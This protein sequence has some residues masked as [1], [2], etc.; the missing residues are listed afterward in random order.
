MSQNINIVTV[1]LG[2]PGGDNKQLFA[3]RAPSDALGGGITILAADVVNGAN[4]GAGTSFGLALLKYSSAG[5]PALNGTIAVEIGGTA[6]P[7][8]AS[9]PKAFTISSGFVDAGEWV[10]AQYE[11]YTNGNPTNGFLTIHYVMGK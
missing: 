10:V 3:F 11:E 2:D 9:V 6:S 5:T 4:T 1:A 7:F 8:T